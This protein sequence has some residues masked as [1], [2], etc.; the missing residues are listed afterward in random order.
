MVYDVMIRGGGPHLCRVERVRGVASV[1]AVDK[2]ELTVFVKAS[3][4]RSEHARSRLPGVLFLFARRPPPR[5]ILFAPH[6]LRLMILV[7]GARYRTGDVSQAV[8]RAVY[9]SENHV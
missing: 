1:N 5:A 7:V 8:T 9:Y 4:A 3:S 2:H 6:Q